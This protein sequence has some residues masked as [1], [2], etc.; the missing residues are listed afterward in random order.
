MSQSR[1]VIQR[2]RQ[3]AN[4]ARSIGIYINGQKTGLIKNGEQKEFNVP[5]GK[6]ELFAKIDWCK[7]KPAVLNLQEGQTATFELGSP[8]K[9]WKIFL[10]FWY[11]LFNTSNWLYLKRA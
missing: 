2:T 6:I 8:L 10:S 9:G 7:T 3:Y 5:A 4:S 1:I 11:A